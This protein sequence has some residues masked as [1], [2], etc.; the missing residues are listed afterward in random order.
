MALKRKPPNRSRPD[1]SANGYQPV[2]QLVYL[3]FALA[4][5]MVQHI[6]EPSHNLDHSDSFCTRSTYEHANPKFK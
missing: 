6:S 5:A 1:R 3:R 2:W 4:R